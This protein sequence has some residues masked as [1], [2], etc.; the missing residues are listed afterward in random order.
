MK[1]ALRTTGLPLADTPS[2]IIAVTPRDARHARRLRRTLLVAG[3]YPSFIHYP[4]GSE[5]GYFRFALSS[6]H[7]SAQLGQLVKVL[8][9]FERPVKVC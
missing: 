6:E 1:D 7:T 4:G 5:S 9:D 8:S 2:P 3:L